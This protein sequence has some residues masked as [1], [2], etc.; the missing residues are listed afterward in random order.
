MSRQ[1]TADNLA[2]LVRTYGGQVSG[3]ETTAQLLD[4]LEGLAPTG[5]TPTQQAVAAAV[6]EYL[7]RNVAEIT[8]SDLD[9]IFGD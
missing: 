4:M 7:E 3:D 9:D 1:S 6:D 8:E 2:D 5:G